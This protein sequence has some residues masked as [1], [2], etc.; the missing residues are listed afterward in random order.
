MT[1]NKIYTRYED[2]P[3]KERNKYDLTKY[4]ETERK[5][6]FFLKI[7]NI[8]RKLGLFYWDE[9]REIPTIGTGKTVYF[10][11]AKKLFI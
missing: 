1:R 4:F 8:K 9:S 5:Y 10:R 11:L 3:T 2:I 6:Q 7:Q